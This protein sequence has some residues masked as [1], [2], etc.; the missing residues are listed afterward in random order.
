MTRYWAFSHHD[1]DTRDR[2]SSDCRCDWNA[3]HHDRSHPFRSLRDPYEPG[4]LRERL[5]AQVVLHGMPDL[6]GGD[7]NGRERF[8]PENIGR[9]AD[10]FG[11]RI[12]VVPQLGRLDRDV[13]QVEPI[14]Q[15]P[16]QFSARSWVVGAGR[17]MPG[18]YPPGPELRTHNDDRDQ[19]QQQHE[20]YHISRSLSCRVR[21]SAKAGGT[22][23]GGIDPFPTQANIM[24]GIRWNTLSGL[25]SEWPCWLAGPGEVCLV[26]LVCLVC[27]VG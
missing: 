14:E 11:H 9:Q 27:L 25:S 22:E 19:N 7:G 1:D 16:G 5:V 4:A 3:H 2:G 18:K 17:T 10:G 15:M 23:V 20:T 12:V 21:Y 8:S 6:V 26:Y 24:D 13:R